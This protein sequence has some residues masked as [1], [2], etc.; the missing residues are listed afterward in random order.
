VAADDAAVLLSRDGL[1]LLHRLAVE[2]GNVAGYRSPTAEERA[3]VEGLRRVRAPLRGIRERLRHGQDG[4]A[5]A[6][7]GEGE[8]AVR[9]VRADADAVVLSLPAA[10][11]GE[12]LAGAAAVHR[13]LG[14]DELRTRTGCSPAECAALL[15]RLHAGLP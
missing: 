3:A 15:A 12:V 9:L 6:S 10:V 11:L 5:P 13:S 1:F 4:P 2:A 8:A 14:D 7:P